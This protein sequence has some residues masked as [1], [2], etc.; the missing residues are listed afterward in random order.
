MPNLKLLA[1]VIDK[2]KTV[3]EIV[4]VKQ[5]SNGRCTF[6]VEQNMVSRMQYHADL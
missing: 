3:S 2:M 1:Q 6:S 4:E 5:T